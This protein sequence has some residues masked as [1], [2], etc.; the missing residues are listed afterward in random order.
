MNEMT[1]LAIKHINDAIEEDSLIV[2]VGAGVS[3][4]SGLPKWSELID[5]FKDELKIDDKEN[6]YLKIAQYYFDS[7][8][9]TNTFRK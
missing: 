5:A 7:V 8:G 3:A 2:F 6:D 9:N 4:N 1:K